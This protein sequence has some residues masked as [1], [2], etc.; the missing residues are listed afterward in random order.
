MH[1]CYS[2]QL[3]GS[4][5]AMDY[6]T[7]VSTKT[8]GITA[9]ILDWVILF[10]CDSWA[11]MLFCW[12]FY[13]NQFGGCHFSLCLSKTTS[14]FQAVSKWKIILCGQSLCWCFSS[15]YQ[16]IQFCRYHIS[17]LLGNIKFLIWLVGLSILF[18]SFQLWFPSPDAKCKEIKICLS[19]IAKG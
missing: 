13:F 3:F 7:L 4:T 5:Y 11:D 2:M 19:K 16:A 6:E 8:W 9:L 14:F 17:V 12:C 18:K 10:C 15:T 1:S